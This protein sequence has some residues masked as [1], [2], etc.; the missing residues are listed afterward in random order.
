MNNV[1][2]HRFLIGMLVPF[3]AISGVGCGPPPTP[4]ET[5]CAGQTCYDGNECT[6]DVCANDQCMYSPV[7]NGT[8]CDGG[9]GNCQQG[10]CELGSADPLYSGFDFA[11]Q[12]GDFWEYRYK[13]YFKS[14]GGGT[15]IERYYGRF[16]LTLGVPTMVGGMQ[17][18]P[19]AISGRANE[20]T[21]VDF[22][23]RWKHLA[24]EDNVFY[25]SDGGEMQVIF[26][27]QN[28]YWLG[29]GFIA[30]WGDTVLCAAERSTI[31]NSYIRGPALRAGLSDSE[32][33]CEYFPGIGQICGDS[34][35]TSRRYDFFQPNIGPVGYFFFNTYTDCG[36]G[37][38]SGATWDHDVGLVASSLR[39]DPG[40]YDL[41]VEP[42]DAI[43]QAQ[44][45]EWGRPVLGD[46]RSSDPGFDTILLAGGDSH[47]GEYQIEDLYRITVP[48]AGGITRSVSIQLN[49]EGAP[50]DTDLDLYLYN[51]TASQALSWS[52]RDNKDVGFYGEGLVESLAGEYLIGVESHKTNYSVAAGRVEYEIRV[53]W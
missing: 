51:S 23:P 47:S 46:V 45:L 2:S 43:A 12:E 48:S 10:T 5:S 34:S 24:L 13:Y 35:Y 32:S 37:F 16:R 27:A 26:D 49:F 50:A 36:G 41:E 11:L 22:R 8:S 31:D 52:T 15:E 21:K 4:E 38:C 19:V 20:G 9:N 42:N 29:G 30:K 3:S 40:D 14:W 53:S 44:V 33:Q 18:F 7:A 28:G 1:R 17:A 25:G 39:G 6:S